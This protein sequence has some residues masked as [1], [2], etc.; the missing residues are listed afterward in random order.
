MNLPHT[1]W[2]ILH[3]WRERLACHKRV[4]E[5]GRTPKDESVELARAQDSLTIMMVREPE[6]TS[7]HTAGPRRL[8]VSDESRESLTE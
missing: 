3:H 1:A 2:W 6:A 5:Q 4:L 7:R 8:Y